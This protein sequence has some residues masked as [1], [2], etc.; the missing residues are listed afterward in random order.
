[1]KYI[2]ST[3]AHESPAI[4]KKICQSL[5]DELESRNGK[6]GVRLTFDGIPLVAIRRL[7]GLDRTCGCWRWVADASGGCGGRRIRISW[8]ADAVLVTW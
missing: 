6:D 8:S 7:A 3:E 2:C 4:V 1:M 5:I